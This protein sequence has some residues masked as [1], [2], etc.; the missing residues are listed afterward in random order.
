MLIKSVFGLALFL[1]LAAVGWRYM[2]PDP[3][4]K[5]ATVVSPLPAAISFEGSPSASALLPRGPSVEE[6][7]PGTVRGVRKC[8][9]GS[10]VIYTDQICPKGMQD[11][12]VV[13]RELTVLPS[14][15]VPKTVK[16]PLQPDG[17]G[18]GNAEPSIRAKQMDRLINQ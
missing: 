18:G 15:P 1:I 4:R 17:I 10:T 16:S 9:K 6:Q 7:A 2:G 12:R 11:L 5:S 14:T 3:S 8:K 13:E